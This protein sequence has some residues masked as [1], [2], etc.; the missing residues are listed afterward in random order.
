MG[1]PRSA[2]SALSWF[3]AEYR[4]APMNSRMVVALVV[5]IL[6]LATLLGAFGCASLSSVKARIQHR[7]ALT[8]GPGA[9]VCVARQFVVWGALR[10]TAN[11][12]VEGWGAPGEPSIVVYQDK[13]FNPVLTEGRRVRV[14]WLDGEKVVGVIAPTAGEGGMVIPPVEVTAAIVL[15]EGQDLRGLGEGDTVAVL[16]KQITGG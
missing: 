16:Q 9:A 1:R 12:R 10:T 7:A 15:P 13:G 2:T 4:Q 11:S 14:I 8:E 6:L 5:A 3:R